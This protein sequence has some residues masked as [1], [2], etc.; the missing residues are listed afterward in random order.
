MF[1]VLLSVLF[2]ALC[3]VWGRND[4]QA[5]A[6]RRVT[7]SGC[8]YEGPEGCHY[9]LTTDGQSYELAPDFWFPMPPP[10]HIVTVTGIIKRK[11]LGFCNVPK[12]FI[13]SSI[14]VTEQ[15]CRVRSRRSGAR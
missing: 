2:C 6:V 13:A 15:S 5:E 11:E 14:V 8:T 9:L 3:V 4:A 10:Y 1:R 7:V 12:V